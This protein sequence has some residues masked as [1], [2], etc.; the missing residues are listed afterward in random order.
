[1]GDMLGALIVMCAFLAICWFFSL[2]SHQPSPP[3]PETAPAAAA[4]LTLK[5]MIPGNQY[6]VDLPDGRHIKINYQGYRDYFSQLPVQPAGGANNAA[7]RTY[8]GSLW[9]WTVPVGPSNIPQWIDP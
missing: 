5:D 2:F 7:Y 1:M 8:D 6:W 9:I 4:R 3:S